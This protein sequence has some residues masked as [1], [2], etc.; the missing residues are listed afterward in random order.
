VK[1]LRDRAA[2]LLALLRYGRDARVNPLL[3]SWV[4]WLLELP[5]AVS[6]RDLEPLVH[7]AGLLAD[8]VG[9]LDDDA[10]REAVSGLALHT[11]DLPRAQAARFLALSREAAQRT[12]GMRPFDVQLLACAALLSG[13]AVE[14]DTGEGKTLVGALAAA[15]HV[16]AGRQVHVLS[17]NDYLAQR[18]AQWMGPFF[19]SLGIDVGW[20]GQ[21][22]THAQRQHAY[23]CD[24]V[25]APVSEVGFDV[26]RDRFAVS[27]DGRVDPVL[28]V[29]IVDEAD[30]VMIDEAMVPLVLAGESRHRAE[31]LAEVTALVRDLDDDAFTVDATRT[32]VALTDAGVDRLESGLGLRLFDAENVETLTQV[33]LALHARVLVQRDVDYLVVDGTVKLVNT[34]RGRVAHLQ[35][36]PDGLHAAI[37]AKEGLTATASGVVLDTV[38][39]Q[40]LLAGYRTLSGM[41]GTVVAIAQELSEFYQLRAGRVERNEP[42]QRVDEPDRVFLT[43]EPMLTAVV[44]EVSERHATGQPVLVGTL[45]VAESEALAALLADAG[46][47]AQVLNAK[48]DAEEAAVVARAGEHGTVT[49]STQMSGRGTDIRLGGPDERDHRRVAASG[50]LAVVAVGRYPWHRLDVQL[51]G[52]A[53]R[54][55]DPG[56][57]V[58]F[59]SLDSDLVQV[60][61]PQWVLTDIERNGDTLPMSWRQQIVEDAQIASEG[62]RRDQHRATWDYS[63]TIAAQRSTVLARRH[64]LLTTDL[65]TRGLRGILGDQLDAL[66]QA[67]GRDAVDQAARAVTV[68]YLDERWTDHLAMLQEVKDGI[69]L[70]ALA[71]QRPTEEFRRIALRAFPGFFDT[72][73]RDAAAFLAGLTPDDLGRP[74]EDLGLVR[75]STTWTYMIT[76]NPFGSSGDWRVRK[77]GQRWRTTVLE[78]E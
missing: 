72:V 59:V 54:Q 14:L 30:A 58:T 21:H 1:T 74:L 64:D 67:A 44:A 37:E 48:N 62:V 40:D 13:H 41:S 52:R 16:V 61:V 20:V 9:A 31:S 43:R 32:T 47:T 33:N 53:G 78:I 29:A 69:Y 4:S 46:I 45:S 23:R 5:G 24:V 17:V 63:R 57:S 26:L 76:D 25:Y 49:I 39:V 8:E 36:W 56:M 77:Y 12:L 7:D 6:F 34:A 42:N 3:P 60:N 65:A 11:G 73:D 66:T 22:T 27:D 28:D 2:P 38:T 70:R 51:R 35:R 18:D 15:G 19:A 75:P 71:R 50:G 68:F 10:L 55:G